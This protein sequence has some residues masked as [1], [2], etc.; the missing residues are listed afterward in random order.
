MAGV[1][2]HHVWQLLQRGFAVKRRGQHY[3]WVYRQGS[4]PRELNTRD[5]GA[6]PFFYGPPDGPADRNMTAFE[7]DAQRHVQAWRRS[8]DGSVVDVAQAGPIL[9]FIDMRSEFLRQE[10]TLNSTSAIASLPGVLNSASRSRYFVHELIDHFWGEIVQCL[11]KENYFG[12]T[13]NGAEDLVRCALKKAVSDGKLSFPTL[14]PFLREVGTISQD[15][16]NKSLESDV[17]TSQRLERYL[18]LQFMVRKLAEPCVILPDT[19]IA[20]FAG[21]SVRPFSSND[22]IDLCVLPLRSDTLLIG[23]RNGYDDRSPQ[24]IRRASASCAYKAFIC[25]NDTP[26]NRSMTRLIGKNAKLLTKE[27]QKSLLRDVSRSLF[28]KS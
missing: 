18:K 2:Q 27:H 22:R 11:K 21:D 5:F 12:L 19:C 16:H 25:S 28:R 23:R 9:A 24:V 6:E 15:A 14:E 8:T 10:L 7:N 26:A 20:F 13:E 4:L 3:I 1:D 17:R